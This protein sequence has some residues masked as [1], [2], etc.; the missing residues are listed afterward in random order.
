[1]KTYVVEPLVG[2]GPVRLGMSRE[3]V[4]RTMPDPPHSFLKT[5]HSRHE[6]DSFHGSSFQ[7]FYTGESPTVEYIE[8]SGGAEVRALFGEQSMFETPA[9]ELIA[10]LADQHALE[11]DD[12]SS[13]CDVLFP[14]LQMSLWRP[15]TPESPT[16]EDGRY[17]ATLGLGVTGYFDPPK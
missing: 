9:N 3:E 17:F 12:D 7:V 14:G 10:V 15:Y 11:T 8:L 16:E 1:M 2:I 5:P 4:K 6:T 13:P